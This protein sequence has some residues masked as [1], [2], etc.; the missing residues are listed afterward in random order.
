VTDHDATINAGVITWTMRG[1]SWAVRL[2]PDDPS[3]DSG[4]CEGWYDVHGDAVAFR[5]N[6]QIAGGTCAPPVRTARWSAQN[7]TLTWRAVSVSDYAAV[8]AA[9]PWQKIG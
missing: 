5:T 7:G 8:F 2:D 4:T 1:G 9:K 3:G 6:T